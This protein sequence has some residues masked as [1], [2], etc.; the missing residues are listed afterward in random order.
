MGHLGS[1]FRTKFVLPENLVPPSLSTKNLGSCYSLDETDGS[2]ALLTLL[3]YTVSVRENRREWA[4]SA[5][6]MVKPVLG[7][8]SPL[9]AW[10]TARKKS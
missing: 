3:S 1:Y 7:W 4:V 6:R 9:I 5:E 8:T 10:V 2:S